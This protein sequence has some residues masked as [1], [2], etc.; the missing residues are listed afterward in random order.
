MRSS[1]TRSVYG[2]G[3]LLLPP[4]WANAIPCVYYTLLF[5]HRGNKRIYPGGF[6][7]DDDK[8]GEDVYRRHREKAQQSLDFVKQLPAMS[9]AFADMPRFLTEDFHDAKVRLAHELGNLVS[10]DVE[11][12][13][14]ENK[15]VNLNSIEFLLSS[16]IE[17]RCSVFSR[18]DGSRNKNGQAS[19]QLPQPR[20]SLCPLMFSDRF[21]AYA[22][23][24]PLERSRHRPTGGQ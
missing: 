16:A 13:V 14:W 18:R 22:W 9:Q 20:H 19:M 21:K 1:S 12:R 24:N 2:F 7:D 8:T 11:T 4:F 3:Q 23:L 5:L 15:T 6:D 17:V 10:K